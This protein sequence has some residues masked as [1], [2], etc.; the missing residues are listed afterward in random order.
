MTR[1]IFGHADN[2]LAVTIG[3]GGTVLVGGTAG[4]SDLGV[5]AREVVLRFRDD[6]SLDPGFG[7]GGLVRTALGQLS[8]ILELPDGKLLVVGDAK[9]SAAVARLLS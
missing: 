9:G 7:Q 6:G 2:A 1:D 3:R 5:K 4:L 8:D